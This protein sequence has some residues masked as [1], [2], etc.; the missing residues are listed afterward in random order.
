MSTAEDEGVSTRDA[1]DSRND[2]PYL[3]YS[4]LGWMMTVMIWGPIWVAAAV[5]R[6]MSSGVQ[7]PGDSIKATPTPASYGTTN[8][9]PIQ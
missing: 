3:S 1:P 9:E 5:I 7:N 4:T 8:R 6:M 2:A